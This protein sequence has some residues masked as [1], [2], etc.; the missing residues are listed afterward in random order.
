MTQKSFKPWEG[1]HYVR[2][3]FSCSARAPT[4]G[5]MRTIC[6][7]TPDLPTEIIG[8]ILELDNFA[9]YNMS[10]MKMLSRGLAGEVEPSKKLHAVSGSASR[11]RITLV[12]RLVKVQG[13]HLP[14]P[15]GR[16][17]SAPSTPIY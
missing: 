12:E 13:R 7:P 14:L 17:P 10:F 8:E 16:R 4:H 15:C 9:N 5:G 3:S 1:K 6:H 2:P 11:L